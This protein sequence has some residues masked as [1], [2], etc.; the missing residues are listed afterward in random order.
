MSETETKEFVRPTVEVN[1]YKKANPLKAKVLE[2]RILFRE[3]DENDI[4]HIVLDA[5]E[6]NYLD[7]Q[8]VGVLPPGINEKGNPHA[9]RL[10]SIASLASRIAGVSVAMGVANN[11]AKLVCA[12]ALDPI[13]YDI[14]SPAQNSEASVV[15]MPVRYDAGPINWRRH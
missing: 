5:R 8:S 10:Y 7:G 4:R 13:R 6:M 15:I 14:Q 1:T 11:A 2:N 12:G 9:V 3:G